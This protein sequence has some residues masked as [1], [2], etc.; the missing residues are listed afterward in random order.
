MAQLGHGYSA[1]LSCAFSPDGRCVLTGS[2]DTTARL[3]ETATGKEL[4]RFQGHIGHVTSVAFS[5]DG[6]WVLTGSGSLSGIGDNSA[7]LW[8]TATGKEVRRFKGHSEDVL[9]V[10]FSPKGRHAL[11]GSKDGTARLWETATGKEVRRFQ[12]DHKG[13]GIEV[14]EQTATGKEIRRFKSFPWRGINSVA[15]SPDGRCVLTGSDDNT[16]RLWETATGKEVRRFEGHSEHVSAVAFSPDGHWV[17]TAAG[18]RLNNRD[19]TARLWETATGKEVRRFEG[20]VGPVSAVAFSPNGRW[21]LTGSIHGMVRQWDAATGK[22]V[23][24]FV[25]HEKWIDDVKAVAFSPDGRWVLTQTNHTSLWEAATGK[26]VRWFLGHA[27]GVSAVGFGPDGRWLLIGSGRSAR[28]WEM[29]SGKE[30]RRFIGHSQSVNAVAFSPDGR[31]VLTGAGSFLPGYGDNT[32]RLWE[33]ATGKEMR[34]FVGYSSAVTSVAFSP[35]GRCVLTANGHYSSFS[36]DKT[37]RLWDSATGKEVRRFEGHGDAVTSVAFS[38]DGRWVLTGGGIGGIPIPLNLPTIS[39]VDGKVVVRA[40][41][42]GGNAARTRDTTARLWE[43]ATGKEVRRFKGHS[44][45]LTSVAFS[46]DGRWVLTGAG[47]LSGAADNTARLWETATGK[48]VRRFE[49]HSEAVLSV[50]VAP[51][52]RWLLTGSKDR[53]ARLW[54]TATGKE[55]RRFAGHSQKV[56]SVAFSPDG[57]LALTGSEDGTVGLWDTA[58]GKERC[59]LVGFYDGDWAVVDPEGRFDASNGGDVEG[60]HWVVGNE[61]IALRQLKERYYDPGLL[62]KYMGFNKEPLRKVSAFREV[63]LFPE[64]AVAERKPGEKKLTLTLTNRGGGIGRVQVLVNGKELLA[65]A[66]GAK[67]NV[68]AKKANLTVDLSSVQLIPGKPNKVEIV[69]WNAEGYLSSRGFVRHLPGPSEAAEP[70]QLHAIVAGVGAYGNSALNLRFAAKDA[71][72]FATALQLGGKRLFGADKVHLTLLTTSDHPRAIKPTKANLAKAFADLKK[73]KPGDV[74]VIYLAGHGVALQQGNDL[75][76]YL[77]ADARSLDLAALADPAVRA[78]TTVSSEELTQWIK[79]IPALKQVMVLDTCAA[80][81]AAVKLT[82][83]RDVSGD[84]VRAI[85]RLKDRTGFH[86][87]MGCSADRVSYEA[88]QYAQGLLT[89]SL[90]EGMRGTA[91]REGEYV[92]VSKLFQYAA[93]RVPELARN[94]GGVQRPLVAA[95]RGTSFDVGRMGM[96]ERAKVPLALVKP[97]V[98]RPALLNGDEA[99]DNL[100]LTSLL[101]QRLSNAS[102]PAGRGKG[103]AI[104]YVSEDD[105]PGAVRPTGIYTVDGDKVSVRLIL[106]RDGVVVA[107]LKVE[108]KKNDLPALAEKMAQAV[109]QGAK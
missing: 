38:P 103:P 11:T 16:A 46:A 97:V 15:F 96:A 72:D 41:A 64:V 20:H 48:E 108:G 8:E 12:A 62:A 55:V 80:G 82:E 54:D 102:Q 86:V 98:L 56:N 22:E 57:R 71:E 29:A 2:N 88:S 4:R 53:T 49:G 13:Q 17:L 60:L 67:P 65:D 9:A 37:A 92:D 32:A 100:K 87:L 26:E 58:T 104:V 6:R 34:R 78:A 68:H 30:V 28:L 36:G 33:K 10:A 31:C 63:K 23:R 44:G 14:I 43:T 39:F 83:K 50:A 3:W 18:S 51:D 99:D 69:A 7:R 93:D 19:N 89:Y 74:L 73:V 5:R 21:V 24:Q 76:C 107:R 35:D 101:R 79:A 25:G 75:Y 47:S 42:A 45:S 105:F 84:Q 61:A 1:V 59:S 85:E 81:A 94:I 52:G 109:L 95:P 70:M 40:N 66:R 106:K 91:L 27:D 77:T 90:L